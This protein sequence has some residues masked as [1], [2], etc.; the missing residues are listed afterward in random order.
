MIERPPKFSNDEIARLMF[1][2]SQSESL[3]SLVDKINDNYE[4]WDSVKYKP[5][6]IGC[7][8]CAMSLI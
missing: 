2:K 4:Y 3:N 1:D 8:A 7:N 6:L 5:L